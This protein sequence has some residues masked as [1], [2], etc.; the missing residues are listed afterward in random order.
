MS[1]GVFMGIRAA[2]T[3]AAQN[4]ARAYLDAINRAL[5]KAGLPDYQ[6][7]DTPPNVYTKSRFGRSAL[8]HHSAGSLVELAQF[9]VSQQHP[10]HLQLIAANPYRISFV[11]TEFAAPLPTDY[12]EAIGGLQVRIW[13]GSVHALLGELRKLAQPLGIPLR[14]EHLPDDVAERINDLQPLAD[15]DDGS[16]AEDE[17]TAWLLLHEGALL[18]SAHSVALSLAG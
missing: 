12:S 3:D 5:R 14:G 16:L 8:D 1:V 10:V 6:D 2:Y 13:V 7:P 9:A 17:R 11:P 15:N 18:A 4:F